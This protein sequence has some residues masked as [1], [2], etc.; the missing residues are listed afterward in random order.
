[1]T[2]IAV[3]HDR[4]F[5]DNVAEWILELDR[6]EGIPWK[7]NYSSWLDQKTKRMVQEEKQVSKRRKSLERELEWVRMNPKGRQAKSK[8]RL[9]S[10]D[11]LMSEEQK[12]KEQRLEI[13]I[14]NG[15]RLGTQVIDAKHVKK[16]FGDKLLYEDLNF[17]LPP[18][19]IVGIV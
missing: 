10:Y 2:V 16:A 3:T 19:G 4:Y 17:N 8:A 18:A 5:L 13:Y 9:N 15:P 1:G 11:K 7:G 6:G 14:P 12:D